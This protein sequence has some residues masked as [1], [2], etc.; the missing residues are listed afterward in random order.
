MLCCIGSS[1]IAR[2]DSV[3]EKHDSLAKR[4]PIDIYGPEG[5]RDMVRAI[6]QL[7]YS[8][9]AAEYRVHELK[10]VPSHGKHFT[11]R[12]TTRADKHERAGGTDIYPDENGH[13]HLFKEDGYSVSA[14]P[15]VHT[16]PCVGYVMKEDDQKGHLNAEKCREAIDRSRVELAKEY[17]DPMRVMKKL[18]ALCT[19]ESFTFPNG[20]VLHHQDISEPDRPGRKIVIMG[21]TSSGRYIESLAQGADLLVHEATNAL[22]SREDIEKYGTL[23]GLERETIRH[24]H[25]SPQMAGDFAKQIGAK[26]LILTHFSPRYLGDDSEYSMRAMWKIEDMAREA[27]G[28]KEPNDVIAAWDQMQMPV[29]MN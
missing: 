3:R 19:N 12:V 21:D 1:L 5:T 22:L 10:N 25:S 24:G 15:M 28:L 23:N 29:K 6:T 27:S 16:V 2:R 11:Q 4:E 8:G 7:S 20:E 9:A 13:Y 17:G 14:A 18:K 26:R